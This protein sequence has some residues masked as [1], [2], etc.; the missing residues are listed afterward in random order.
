M[1]LTTHRLVTAT[2]PE[3]KFTAMTNPDYVAELPPPPEAPAIAPVEKV[4][5]WKHYRL[6]GPR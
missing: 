3:T 1:N 5:L 6:I 4:N 2:L